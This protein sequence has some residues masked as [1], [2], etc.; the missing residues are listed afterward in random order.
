MELAFEG[1]NIRITKELSD[2]DHF[3]LDFARMLDSLEIK[4]VIVSGFVSIFFGRSRATEDVDILIEQIGQDKFLELARTAESSGM[5]FLNTKNKKELYDMLTSKLSVRMAPATKVIPN[6][7]LKFS[8]G[9]INNF[10]L[11]NPITIRTLKG[12]MLFS[13][14]EVQIAFKFHLGSEKDIEDAIYLYELFR[15]RLDLALLHSMALKLG[16]GTA[17]KKYGVGYEKAV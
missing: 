17:M 2:L 1:R 12:S 7:E 4:Y 3:V 9:G 16:V 10:S 15:E 14:I 5:W 11:Q 6:I 8:Q 13:P